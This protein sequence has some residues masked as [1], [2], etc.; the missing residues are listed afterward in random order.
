M[1][2]RERQERNEA[3]AAGFLRLSS[4]STDAVRSLYYHHCAMR[5]WP[6]IAL[7]RDGQRLLVDATAAAGVGSARDAAA[8]TRVLGVLQA[9]LVRRVASGVAD[10]R[11][12]LQ[13]MNA[14]TLV[15]QAKRLAIG[16]REGSNEFKLPDAVAPAGSTPSLSPA[17]YVCTTGKTHALR[18]AEA[19]VHVLQEAG[20]GAVAS[21]APQ[22][23]GRAAAQ[24]RAASRLDKVRARRAAVA[25]RKL[26]A[27]AAD[28]LA[29]LNL[30]VRAGA[31]DGFIRARQTAAREVASRRRTAEGAQ[32]PAE[33]ALAGAA[34]KPGASVTGSAATAE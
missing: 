16:A 10:L 26:S 1:N 11:Q 25:F 30:R 27:L 19:M 5:R 13:V 2:E 8:V 18:L 34:A 22:E 29:M 28:P 3:V 24:A 32:A 21:G 33:V 20:A 6:Y 15:E 14:D 23:V 7:D 17:F 9:L 31:M 4:S 12:S